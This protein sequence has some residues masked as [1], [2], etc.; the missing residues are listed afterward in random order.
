MTPKIYLSG[1]R[2]AGSR[3]A[4]SLMERADRLRDLAA[5]AMAETTAKTI[6]AGG[7]NRGA[8]S[9]GVRALDCDDRLG[10]QPPR[11]PRPPPSR[12]GGVRLGL[13][14]DLLTPR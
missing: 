3:Y 8:I 13:L 11:P 4:K 12:R 5:A 1:A 7:K 9:L 10:G 2:C 14:R 6:R